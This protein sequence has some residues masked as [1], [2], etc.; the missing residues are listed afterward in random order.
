MDI[1]YITKALLL[2]ICGAGGFYLVMAFAFNYFPMPILLYGRTRLLNWAS[3]RHKKE[4]D[5]ASIAWSVGRI[6]MIITMLA[7]WVAMFLLYAYGLYETLPLYLPDMQEK[8]WW[9]YGLAIAF[10]LLYAIVRFISFFF[11]KDKVYKSPVVEEDT[12]P[13]F[14]QM[15]PQDS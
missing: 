3:K 4:G 15:K 6:L 7:I 9:Y 2:G 13:L 10:P 12:R 5:L 1:I 8:F 11:A 14:E